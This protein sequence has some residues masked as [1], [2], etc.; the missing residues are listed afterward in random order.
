MHKSSAV[1]KKKRINSVFVL[2]FS[3]SVVSLVFFQTGIGSTTAGF[4]D[5]LFRPIQREIYSLF[6]KAVTKQDD[7]SE[8]IR[9]RKENNQLR[10]AL[11]QKE[12]LNQEIQALRDQFAVSQLPTRRLIPARI[13]GITGFIPGFSFPNEI[14]L[15]RGKKQ[16]LHPGQVVVSKNV[17]I[18]RITAVTQSA[19]KV[20]LSTD[21]RFS[22]TAKAS[23]TNA[24]G[25][26]SGK[27]SGM[28]VFANVLLTEDLQ[29][30]DL[31]LTKG[32]TNLQSIGS[33]PDL[34]LGKITSINKKASELFQSAEVAPLVDVAH[35]QT[36]FVLE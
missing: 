18:G 13:V 7:S 11:S 27:G 30:G 4:F 21:E 34:V 17:L 20:E 28:M 16:G 2:F 26:L 33:P 14:I 6:T 31:V 29:K 5:S 8:I 24:L 3:L 25:V 36:V 15:D 35:L 22:L 19:A 10:I 23:K 12:Q 9:L 32:S 1:I